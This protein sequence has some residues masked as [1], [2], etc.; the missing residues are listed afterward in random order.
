[1]ALEI[2]VNERAERARLAYIAAE[3]DASWRRAEELA[4]II[5]EELELGSPRA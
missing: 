3:L 1:V 4:A 5:D 2:A